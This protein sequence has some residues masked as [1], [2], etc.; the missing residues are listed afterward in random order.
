M[1]TRQPS[2]RALALAA[3]LALFLL[4]LPAEA[5]R[6]QVGFLTPLG[7]PTGP[8]LVVYTQDGEVL[9][10]HIARSMSWF[11][12]MTK[13]TF[14]LE[15][16]SRRK[17]TA[18]EVDRVIMPMHKIWQIAMIGE[19]TETLEKIWRTDFDR[20]FEVD[21]LVFDSVR[22]PKS[23]RTS[24]RQLINPGFDHRLRV[25]YLPSSKEGKS[26][27]GDLPKAV[28]GD[29]PKA[30]LVVKD[31]GEA[32]RVKQGDYR[33]EWFEQLFGD[34]PE[35][36]ELYQGDRRKFKFFAEHT[37]VYDQACPAPTNTAPV[38]S[39]TAAAAEAAIAP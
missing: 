13:M 9:E 37:F 39:A 29:M 16:G 2:F 8:E 31:D 28:F 19:A 1:M 20:I 10:G 12:S 36:L 7:E 25:Y 17:L 23:E 5:R 22:H 34:C 30:F 3:L 26:Y 33:K 35:V 6:P 15:D 27:F 24:L 4:A 21:E 11:G 32:V 18:A 14:E 38:D